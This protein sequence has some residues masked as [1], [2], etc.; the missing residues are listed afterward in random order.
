MGTCYYLFREDPYGAAGYVGYDLGKAGFWHAPLGAGCLP[1]ADTL[2]KQ[3]LDAAGWISDDD[4]AY[5]RRVAEDII[6]WAEGKSFVFVSEHDYLYERVSDVWY[7]AHPVGSYSNAEWQRREWLTG[8]RFASAYAG[9]S[10]E[11]R[12]ATRKLRREAR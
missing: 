9:C 3:L 10:M 4:R 5:V 12:A 8:S 1:D 11:A 2:T 7:D 6:D